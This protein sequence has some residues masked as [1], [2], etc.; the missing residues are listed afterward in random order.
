MVDKTLT[1]HLQPGKKIEVIGIINK[2][3]AFMTSKDE[4]QNISEF[5]IHA[6]N[7]LSLEEEEDITLSE[8]D[9]RQIKE[10]AALNP[11]ERL[12]KSLSPE[13]YGDEEI[14]RAVVLQSVKGVPKLQSDGTYTREDIHILLVGDPGIGKSKLMD[15]TINKVPRSRK[16]V[17]TKTSKVG[18]GAMAVKDE[19]TGTWS[20]EI[21]ALILSSGS[22]LCIDELDKMN[23]EHLSE[24]LEPMSSGTCSINKAGIS[25]RLNA[26]TTILAGA[27]PK[28]SGSF[29]ISQP[30]A[31]QIDLS[32]PILNRFDLIFILID[33]PNVE[34][35]S[36][37]LEHVFGSMI[38]KREPEINQQLFK[39]YIYYCR[40]LK[41]KLNEDILPALKALYNNLRQMSTKGNVRYV[42][43]N[44]RN[45]EGII[46][47]AEASAKI[48]LSEV[49]EKYDFDIAKKIFLYSLKQIGI[50]NETGL[51]DM[52]RPT[53]KFPVSKRGKM[54]SILE[55]I[56]TLTDRIG[57]IV[58]YEE[59]AKK[60]EEL[61]ISK[62]D[63]NLVL[64]QLQREA[65]I[66]EPNRGHFSLV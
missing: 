31:S 46:R 17:G 57:K 2:L 15:A 54:E 44:L 33:K 60:A 56:H 48:R 29:N 3:P 51:I 20:L 14:C 24:L 63:V 53:E 65:L 38:K 37:A 47:L 42:P 45:A 19:L 49:V 43:I 30:I 26:R 22:T 39:K 36:Q 18:L 40:K 9:L 35:D 23:P 27:N 16:V 6:N 61:K 10:I 32:T 13:R 1:S 52:S 12:A 8:E 4:E 55:I 21:G 28:G 50:D 34:N 11:L 5:M 41:P 64:E 62:F 58:P 59:I 7:I 25:A 66:M